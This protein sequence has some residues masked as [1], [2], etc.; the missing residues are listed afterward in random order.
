MDIQKKI[1]DFEDS[2]KIFAHKL[3]EQGKE[4]EI[5]A[6]IL[7]KYIKGVDVTPDEDV[8]LKQNIYDTLKIAGIGIPFI[9]IP[10]A[11]IILPGLIILAKKHNINLLPSKF[12]ENETESN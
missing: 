7:E 8:L 5:A 4:T 12:I 1:K 2:L 6:K 3:D 10:G 11:S 9:L